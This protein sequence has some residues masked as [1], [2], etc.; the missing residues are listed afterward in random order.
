VTA[1]AILSFRQV[2]GELQEQTERRLRQSSKAVGLV[3]HKRLLTLDVT[4]EPAAQASQARL[5]DGLPRP[6]LGIVLTTPDG[7]VQTVA[8]RATA[9]PALTRHQLSGL[10]AG[11][12]LLVVSA[13]EAGV[14]R[15]FLSRSLDP[16]Q[17][18]RGTLH[19]EINPAY[20]WN[21]EDEA[22]L[23]P[24]MRVIVLD[25]AGRTLYSSFPGSA[26]AEEVIRATFQGPAGRFTWRDQTDEYLAGYWSLFL[27]GKF[28]TP[29]WTIVI[30]RSRADVLAPIA[31]FNRTFILI[32]LMSLW[33]VL[34]LSVRQIRRI[35][36]PLDALQAAT[37][38]LAIGHLDTRVEVTSRDEFAELGASF[39][40]MATQLGRQFDAL[41]MRRE[42][43]VALARSEPLPG[44]LER[45]AELLAR[46]L[47][48]A[49]V[50]VW[51]VGSDGTL[52][53]R[54]S[55]GAARRTDGAHDRV[56]MG[57]GEIGRIA[58][59]RRPFTTS[60]LA[61]DPRASD[62]AWVARERLVALVG[63]PLLV[64]GRVVGVA[65]A[66]ATHPLEVLD[67]ASFAWAA[68]EIAQCVERRRVE[69][70]LQGSEQQVR[71]L[72]KMEAVGR[73]AGGIAHDF[74]NLLTVIIG[75]SQ[76]LLGGLGRDDPRRKAVET[77]DATADRAAQLTRQLLAFSRK[78]V[79]APALLDINAVITGMIGI[80][81]RLIG[82]SV[83][84]I[85][86]PGPEPLTVKVD[87]GQIE[88]VL[89]NLVVNARD[90]MP[91]GGT[92]T[93]EVEPVELDGPAAARIPG[94][95]PGAH[96][97]LRVRDT[98]TG[99]SPETLARIFEPFFTTKEP[100]KGTG[101]GLA[102]VFGIVAQSGGAIQVESELDVGTE[103]RIYLP[104]ATGEISTAPELGA[105]AARGSETVLLVEDESDVRSLVAQV[106]AERGYTV[107]TA[108]RP[109]EALRVAE[110]HAGP[111]HLLLTD[112]VM[113]EMS[114]AALAGRL[115]PLR[116]EM[117][118]LQMSGYTDY[119]GAADGDGGQ[120]FLQKPF[121]PEQVARAVRAALDAAVALR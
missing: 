106:L 57:E 71:Q 85:F 110:R 63:H 74:N 86:T 33:I 34:L 103:F 10:A 41:T 99:M 60:A 5:D 45:V 52:E 27:K 53:L 105:P 97:R 15:V 51:Q 117:A 111:I 92:I 29:K 30:S 11:K 77:I 101:L 17:P 72:Q 32:A 4:I 121:T 35:M 87:R 6:F 120:A 79:L 78:Q 81:R 9:L 112:M 73:L 75:Y 84:L 104:C 66:Y 59:E 100:G 40:Q 56:A 42:I 61:D 90:A 47:D 24:G 23:E 91:Q 50:A 28:T 46:H 95:A 19:G 96:A 65:A 108:A 22:G 80:L 114:G 2:T 37:R 55:A 89:V 16:A 3:L 107:L 49:L 83:Q 44:V 43:S 48:L 76:I 26:V 109:A 64:D 67:L 82:E 25:E 39:N 31:D 58:E 94:L 8:G 1:L 116:P 118:V 13:G 70:A 14:A 93:I 88:Q 7:A 113:P 20:L 21:V 102:T 54:A 36:Q 98:G 38:R 62:P 115:A 18:Q 68:D 12:I 69:D 119:G